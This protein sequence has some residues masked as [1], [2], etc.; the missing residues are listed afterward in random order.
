[1]ILPQ[2]PKQY[3]QQNEAT[4]RNDIGLELD[5]RFRRGGTVEIA[6]G[7]LVLTDTV[8]GDRWEITVENGLLSLATVT[9]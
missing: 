9:I 3:D 1:M 4:T 2:A 8:T 6:G 5:Q 7:R